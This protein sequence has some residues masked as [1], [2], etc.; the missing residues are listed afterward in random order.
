MLTV[1]RCRRILGEKVSHLSD[2]E[3]AALCSSYELLA[4]IALEAMLR[5]QNAISHASNDR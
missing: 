1:E 5:E 2:E 4:E 3:V